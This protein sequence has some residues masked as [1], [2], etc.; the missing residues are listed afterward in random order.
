MIARR[1]VTGGHWLL[2]AAQPAADDAANPASLGAEAECGM[3]VRPVVG[4]E[5]DVLS[6]HGGN[7]PVHDLAAV[8]SPPA[9]GRGPDVDQI[10]VT[11]AV[12]EDPALGT[13]S[14]CRY[15]KITAGEREDDIA[16][17]SAL[18]PTTGT[19]RAPIHGS[20]RVGLAPCLAAH[21]T[22]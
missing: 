7:R 1:W 19:K 9:P 8:A 12:T 17:G 11:D 2:A 16:H 10:G 6:G 4:E 15:P 5:S 3:E 20:V 22:V 14:P 18:P 13:M 21:R